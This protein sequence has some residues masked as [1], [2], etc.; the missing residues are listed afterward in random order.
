M[1]KAVYE[2]SPS[3]QISVQELREGEW[4]FTVVVC[5]LLPVC[6]LHTQAIVN[7]VL[8]CTS[9]LCIVV[10]TASASVFFVKTLRWWCLPGLEKRKIFYRN[11]LD[12][13]IEL[14][15]DPRFKN[16][17]DYNAKPLFS[18]DQRVFGPLSSGLF[19]ELQEHLH[20]NKTVIPVC[21]Y[22]DATEFYTSV[23]AHPVL[24]E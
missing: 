13:C 23:T 20:P 7:C 4:C 3:G 17:I 11:F 8:L 6:A 2:V 9:T 1:H 24:C 21:I 16:C 5:V 10:C 22:S 15:Q 12:V 19:W 18:G 14:L